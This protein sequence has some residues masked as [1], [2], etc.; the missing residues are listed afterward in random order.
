L[1]FL[2]AKE[3]CDFGTSP[4]FPV[5][6]FLSISLF[7]VSLLF[8]APSFFPLSAAP[9]SFFFPASFAGSASA[10]GK[11]GSAEKSITSSDTPP[12]FPDLIDAVLELVIFFSLALKAR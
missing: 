9:A 11:S 12:F 4:I 1:R 8:A 6:S 3:F 5:S 10:A 2:T 7:P